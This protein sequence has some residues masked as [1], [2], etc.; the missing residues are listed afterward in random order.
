MIEIDGVKSRVV[1][2]RR[3][4]VVSIIVARAFDSGAVVQIQRRNFG[5]EI[6]A[7]DHFHEAVDAAG[8]V[9]K[10]AVEVVEGA[11]AQEAIGPDVVADEVI[12]GVDFSIDDGVAVGH[13]AHDGDGARTALGHGLID[14]FL[15]SGH[16]SELNANAPRRG[17]ER[18]FRRRHSWESASCMGGGQ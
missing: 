7:F 11:H 18:L 16:C 8:F 1:K 17:G 15:T 6:G 12:D 4:F 9:A 3:F 2:A 13:L 10:D 14:K 5:V